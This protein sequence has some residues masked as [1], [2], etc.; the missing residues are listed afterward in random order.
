MISGDRSILNVKKGAFYYTLE[1]FSKHWDRIDVITPHVK[2]QSLKGVPLF[3]N[4][5]FH[6]SPHGLWYQPHWIVTQG[7]KLI[8][9]HKHSVMTVH[10]YPPFY[11]G[12]GARRLSK[13]TGVPYAMEVHHIVGYP[14][15]AS[16]TELIG[17]WMSQIYLVNDLCDAKAVRCVSQG[18]ITVLEQWGAYRENLF[19][20]PSFYLDK[21]ALQPDH[22]IP[23]QYDVVCWGRH[24]ANKR[25]DDVLRAVA[26]LPNVTLLIGGD[27]PLKAALEKLAVSLGIADRVTFAGWFGESAEV[28]RALQSAHVAVVNSKS[29]G[30]P[31]VALEA[32]A[33]GM[34]LIVTQVG[35]M[36]EVIRDGENGL[37]T[38]GT[39]NDLAGKISI[40]MNNEAVRSKMGKAAEHITGQFERGGLIK[41]YADFLKSLAA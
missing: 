38:T 30:G 15:A 8:E 16:L 29:E 31:R 22:S 6:P 28:Y 33:L 26:L 36:P 39:P 19:L 9:Q 7:K 23:K 1:E 2:E 27:G 18:T 24:V 21:E 17:R 40:L 13:K 14:K 5:M 41:G 11:N 3:G 37:F 25:F 32:M 12:V 4:V 10:E 34:P 35:V 20:I